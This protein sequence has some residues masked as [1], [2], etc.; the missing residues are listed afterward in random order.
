MHVQNVLNKIKVHPTGGYHR[1][2][3]DLNCNKS[4]LI[5]IVLW[6]HIYGKFW[7]STSD[8]LCNQEQ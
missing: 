7:I 3:I 8:L 5:Q 6:P 2:N 1:H 4:S